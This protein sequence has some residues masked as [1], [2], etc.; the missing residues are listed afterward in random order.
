MTEAPSRRPAPLPTERATPLDP[1]TGLAP[2]REHQPVSPLAHPDGTAGWLVTSNALVREVLADPR[3]SSR[4]E[5]IHSP[6]RTDPP[7]PAPRGVF[8]GMDAPEHPRYRK[9]LTGQF[10]VRRIRQLTDRIEQI[11]EQA[12]DAT[13]AAG[14]PAD[15]IQTFALPVPSLLIC[16][17]LGV[18]YESHEDFER[19]TNVMSSAGS[20]LADAQAAEAALTA[21]LAGI[22]A[23]KRAR[24]TDDVL[25]GVIHEGSL[26]DEEA[27][28]IALMLLVAGHETTSGMLGLGTLALLTHPGQLAL[29]R[30]DP[31]LIDGAVEEL[32]R[33]VTIAQFDVGVRAALEDVELGGRL[34]RAGDSV[35]VSFIAANRDPDVFDDPDTL[36]ITRPPGRHVA[37]GHGAHACLGQQLARMEL[38]IA[39]P[40]L[41][42]RFPGL[43]LAVPLAEIPIRSEM[44]VY[45]AYRLPVAW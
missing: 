38:R 45:G 29:L 7:T 25:S 41:L 44:P 35:S 20:A 43:R 32:L 13:E 12:L 10:T 19:W 6:M 1:P 3:F 23:D 16:E 31:A 21:F 42:R 8:I 11:V 17:L 28:G 14:Q 15:L 34:I 30:E 26:D 27:L 18:P 36:D 2:L 22:V 5:L 9:L 39:F 24:P 40:A 33:Y 4:S 37:F